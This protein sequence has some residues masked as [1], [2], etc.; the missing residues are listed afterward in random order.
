MLYKCGSMLKAIY[1]E[2]EIIIEC[3][4]NWPGELLVFYSAWNKDNEKIY[5]SF[6]ENK[7]CDIRDDINMLICK[8]DEYIKDNEKEKI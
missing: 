5:Y 4:N 3:N 7:P 2:C 6:G 1:K 8:V